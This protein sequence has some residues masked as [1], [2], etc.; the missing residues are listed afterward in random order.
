MAETSG[1]TPEPA[2]REAGGARQLSAVRNHARRTQRCMRRIGDRLS[3]G[4]ESGPIPDEFK[5][6]EQSCK[7]KGLQQKRGV[8]RNSFLR[9]RSPRS[10]R[11]IRTCTRCE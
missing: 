8:G 1:G 6:F 4:L 7:T 3:V 9:N 11:R 2:A 5:L 10:L